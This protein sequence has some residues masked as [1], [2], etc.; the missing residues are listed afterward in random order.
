MNGT[1]LLIEAA[2]GSGN[3]KA[4]D[5]AVSELCYK[6]AVSALEYVAKNSEYLDTRMSVV[7]YLYLMEALAALRRIMKS[8]K[9]GDA[10]GYA[11]RMLEGREF[12]ED[13]E[14]TYVGSDDDIW[15]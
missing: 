12:E 11:K 7:R 5:L 3:R 2:I 9:H 4:R 1:R 10:R 13:S 14:S 6:D 15:G 8:A